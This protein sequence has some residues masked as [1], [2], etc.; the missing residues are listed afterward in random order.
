MSLGSDIL[1]AAYLV[2]S[3]W[4]PDRRTPRPKRLRNA[5]PQ[6]TDADVDS[7]MSLFKGVDAVV[8]ELAKKGGDAKIGREV[9]RGSLKTDF[10]FL[11]GPGL[12]RAH[13]LVNYYAWHE[14][15]ST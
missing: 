11:A 6:L 2:Y 5:F 15:Y 10:A 3:E 7:L 9:V 14:G 1:G 4:G 8:W 13:F 12:E